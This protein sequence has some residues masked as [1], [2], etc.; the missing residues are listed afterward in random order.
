MNAQVILDGSG[1]TRHVFDPLNSE[2]VDR[3]EERF[4]ALT[5]KG[6]KAV[7]LGR[8]GQPGMLLRSFDP[9]VEQTLFI[10]QLQG[11]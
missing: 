7:A 3:A 11:G 10:P 4:H 2:E 8:D 6:F 9:T 5:A 1:D